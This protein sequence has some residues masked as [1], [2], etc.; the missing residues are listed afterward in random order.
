MAYG[1]GHPTIIDSSCW[2]IAD[3][4]FIYI[5]IE[6]EIVSYSIC[7]SQCE[8]MTIP[9]NGYT[10]RSPFAVLS[11]GTTLDSTGEAAFALGDAW[12]QWKWHEIIWNHH[13][14]SFFPTLGDFSPGL[15]ATGW[16]AR[17][18][19]RSFLDGFGAFGAWRGPKEGAA[20]SG[21]SWMRCRGILLFHLLNI[22]DYE[23]VPSGKLT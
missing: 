16:A 11:K 10:W 1:N 8:L 15:A 21:Q 17:C 4:V 6:R 22:W 12:L 18:F 2:V 5:Y 7:K 20:T 23:W 19:R 13:R 3:R 9:Q 14:K